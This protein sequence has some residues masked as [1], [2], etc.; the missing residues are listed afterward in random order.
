[1]NKQLTVRTLTNNTNHI[2]MDV[3]A[4]WLDRATKQGYDTLI[5]A[6]RVASG[7]SVSLG[8]GRNPRL[9]SR[10]ADVAKL[11]HNSHITDWEQV[12]M[13]LSA[14]TSS[15]LINLC[16]WST[17]ECR[18]GCLQT[19]GHLGMSSGQVAMRVRTALLTQFPFEF[20]VMLLA[21]TERHARR[22][23]KCGKKMAQRLNGTSDQPWENTAWLLALL[24]E[25]GVE[26]HFDYTKG[27][28]RVSTPDYYLAHSVTEKTAVEDIRPGN[29]VV[30]DTPRTGLLPSSWCGMPTIDGDHTNGDL[31]FL[32]PGTNPDAVVL[33]RAKGK[34]RGVEGSMNGFVKPAV[35]SLVS[36]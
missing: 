18:Q 4:W 35:P 20:Y 26:Q 29:V 9:L 14:H 3:A 19:S 17:P 25:A 1:M 24:R 27:H 5:G 12:V 13:Y 7:L 16:P 32:D 33:L 30:V 8:G 10:Q 36:V 22:I 11:T 23:H 28:R 31:R 21:E 6:K 34:L 2:E 15:G